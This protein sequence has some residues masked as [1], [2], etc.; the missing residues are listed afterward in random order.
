MNVKKLNKNSGM[1]FDFK[2]PQI[3]SLYMK[4]TYIP[5]DVLFFNDN[6]IIMEYVE[7]MKPHDLKSIKSKKIQICT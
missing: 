1:L 7:N 3:I 2:K 5:L 4:N 6:N